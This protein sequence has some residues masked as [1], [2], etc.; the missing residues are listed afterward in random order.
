MK[1]T[2]LQ[3][4]RD[5][6]FGVL[7]TGR[8]LALKSTQEMLKKPASLD[9]FVDTFF[10]TMIHHYEPVLPLSNEVLKHVTQELTLAAQE[11]YHAKPNKRKPAAPKPKKDANA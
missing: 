8:S 5:L 9:A 7:L 2:F 11:K 1:P 6:G 3:G 10:D 4:V